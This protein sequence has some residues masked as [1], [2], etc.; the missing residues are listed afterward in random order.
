MGTSE[1]IW[2]M[3]A[4]PPQMDRKGQGAKGTGDPQ[5]SDLMENA[6]AEDGSR[7]DN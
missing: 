1:V 5:I 2:L 4:S 6:L 3:R 7:N